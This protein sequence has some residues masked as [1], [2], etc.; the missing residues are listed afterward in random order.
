MNPHDTYKSV[1]REQ[2][3]A[4]S[5]RLLQTYQ[6]AIEANAIG[7]KETVLHCLELLKRT[8]DFSVDP[9]LAQTLN[10]I[11]QDCENALN[12]DRHDAVGEIL[13]TIQGLW[14]ARIKLEEIARSLA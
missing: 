2:A 6:L 13:E 1:A 14:R 12:E 10:L 8:L 7:D 11:Y 3:K 5:Q 9:A 4:A